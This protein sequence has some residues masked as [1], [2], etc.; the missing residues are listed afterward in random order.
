MVPGGVQATEGGGLALFASSSYGPGLAGHEAG[1]TVQFIIQ[2]GTVS[3]GNKYGNMGLSK[4]NT[5]YT[6]YGMYLMT[7]LVGVP[8]LS[9]DGAIW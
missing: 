4:K 9:N 1:H 2:E 6:V 8:Q 7:G 3:A 5:L